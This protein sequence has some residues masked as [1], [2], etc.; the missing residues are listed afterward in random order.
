MGKSPFDRTLCLDSE[1][2]IDGEISEVFDVLEQ[3]DIAAARDPD[4]FS[5]QL[6]EVP[7][8]F[9]EYNTGVIAYNTGKKFDKFISSWWD[10]Y[11]STKKSARGENQPSFRRALYF[12]QIRVATLPTEYNLLVRL[13]GKVYT[14]VKIFHGRLKTIESS[15]GAAR[16]LNMEKAVDNI[17]FVSGRRV[18]TQRFGI[19]VYTRSFIYDL[20]RAI[21]ENGFWR[22]LKQA[23]SR[24]IKQISSPSYLTFHSHKERATGT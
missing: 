12:S 7:E 6:E 4:Y 3:F 10:E 16:Y 24:V 21:G 13:S 20:R 23:I 17:N 5:T 2:Y 14:D 22:T 19:K 18:F 15:G 1:I 8:S 9:P 11:K